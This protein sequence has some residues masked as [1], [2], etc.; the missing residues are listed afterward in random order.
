[1][2]IISHHFLP[3]FIWDRPSRQFLTLYFSFSGQETLYAVYK[4]STYM[5]Y[6]N[7]VIRCTLF[8]NLLFKLLWGAESAWRGGAKD[9]LAFHNKNNQQTLNVIL[10]VKSKNVPWVT[11]KNNPNRTSCFGHTGKATM[12]NRWLVAAELKVFCEAGWPSWQQQQCRIFFFCQTHFLE[13]D[14][15]YL[16]GN[17]F[18]FWTGK[19]QNAKRDY[20]W[21]SRPAWLDKL[22]WG[23]TIIILPFSFIFQV[24]ET[25]NH[26]RV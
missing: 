3:I 12:N 26:C 16:L 8:L 21:C 9:G 17:Y 2:R 25:L 10:T 23:K 1:M 19:Q 20:M 4:F 11:W 14:S 22:T 7:L 6:L 5:S 15:F 18:S 24:Y 13:K